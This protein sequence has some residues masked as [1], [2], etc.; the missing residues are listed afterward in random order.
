VAN[1]Y[2]KRKKHGRR[3]DDNG[4][5]RDHRTDVAERQTEG[6]VDQRTGTLA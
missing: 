4:I 2:I 5:Q 1:K 6:R 3:G